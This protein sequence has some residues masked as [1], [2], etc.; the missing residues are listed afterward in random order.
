M[1]TGGWINL[2]L[3]VGFV[4]VLFAYCIVRVVRGTPRRH[5]LAHV[6]P[7]EKSNVDRR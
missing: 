2:V 6:E 3:S 4:V 7:I 1:T 5:T